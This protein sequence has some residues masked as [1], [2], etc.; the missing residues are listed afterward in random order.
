MLFCSFIMPL[1]GNRSPLGHPHHHDLPRSIFWDAV[2]LSLC[3]HV[4]A[5]DA[6]RHLSRL[7]MCVMHGLCIARWD[8]RFNKSTA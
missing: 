1:P 6:C 7:Q 5:C 2:L 8:L 3:A 4:L